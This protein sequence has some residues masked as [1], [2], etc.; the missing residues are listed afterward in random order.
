MAHDT[1]EKKF[2]L[3]NAH[4]YGFSQA[5]TSIRQEK[6]FFKAYCKDL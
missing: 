3:V 6:S 1:V 4:N 2:D 5:Q